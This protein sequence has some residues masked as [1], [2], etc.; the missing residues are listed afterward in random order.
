[1]THRRGIRQSIVDAIALVCVG[2]A[3]ASC[4]AFL[5][6][7]P[8]PSEMELR[9]WISARWINA[10]QP[11][12]ASVARPTNELALN[13]RTPSVAEACIDRCDLRTRA[14]SDAGLAGN[15]MR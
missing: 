7:G 4:I 6:V 13:T 15:V 3:L 2:G 8:L 1:M 14:H 12:D 5:F 11:I 9:P 10:A